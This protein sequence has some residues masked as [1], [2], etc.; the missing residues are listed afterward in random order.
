MARQK[1]FIDLVKTGRLP[2]SSIYNQG[3]LSYTAMSLALKNDDLQSAQYFLNQDINQQ[4][5]YIESSIK[6]LLQKPRDLTN[7]EKKFLKKLIHTKFVKN[8][9]LQDNDIKL[10]FIRNLLT[11]K[12]YQI[13]LNKIQK[14][15]LIQLF[16]KIISETNFEIEM[17]AEKLLD[18][19]LKQ[20]MDLK[21]SK[22]T[23]EEQKKIMV[24]FIS[25]QKIIKQLLNLGYNPQL[26]LKNAITTGRLN[27][28]KLL[29]NKGAN[30]NIQQDHHCLLFDAFINLEYFSLNR[31]IN[32]IETAIY[33]LERGMILDKETNYI[34][35][36]LFFKNRIFM[37]I[38]INDLIEID[39]LTDKILQQEKE[40]SQ[41]I[42]QFLDIFSMSNIMKN[43]VRISS[44]KIYES[45]KLKK[46]LF[47]Q[48]S[49]N[50]TLFCPSTRIPITAL[51]LLKIGNDEKTISLYRRKLELLIQKKNNL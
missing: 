50:L 10:L 18:I 35:F 13:I 41:Q 21:P 19:F 28:V 1:D 40:D 51:D 16:I 30:Y 42:Q 15:K 38:Y 27:I 31:Q 5:Q 9:I 43:P 26:I 8:I 49:K 6:I 36:N 23:K 22:L 45:L 20:N 39:E 2:L 11:A 32:I 46:F 25:N 33:L 7:E 47:E 34:I 44:G 17:D 24:Y 14:Y 48:K 29:L 3:N 12:E 37:P 4:K